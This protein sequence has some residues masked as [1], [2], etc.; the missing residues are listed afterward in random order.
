MTPAPFRPDLGTDVH[1]LAYDFRTRIGRLAMPG[2]C[3][4]DM[5]GCIR[6]F[7]AIDPS[8]VRIETVAG[9]VADTI[10]VR[11]VTGWIAQAVPA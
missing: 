10:Y 3:C 4:T 9:D 7:I 1:H 8:V 11:H 2:G 6:L 5:A